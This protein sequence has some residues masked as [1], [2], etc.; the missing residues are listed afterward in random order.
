MNADGKIKELDNALVAKW[1]HANALL[2]MEGEVVERAYNN[3][4]WMTRRRG[5]RI[6][7][8]RSLSLRSAIYI[9]WSLCVHQY[10]SFWAL[11]TMQFLIPY[12]N[13]CLKQNAA[14]LITSIRLQTY[15]QQISM[16]I[17]YR[18]NIPQ[19]SSTIITSMPTRTSDMYMEVIELIKKLNYDVNENFR[20]S[21]GMSV[22]LIRQSLETHSAISVNPPAHIILLIHDTAHYIWR[23]KRPLHLH[24]SARLHEQVI[25]SLG[26]QTFSIGCMEWMK[27]KRTSDDAARLEWLQER[28]AAFKRDEAD[29]P[30]TNIS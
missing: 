17:M 23:Q 5:V 1:L 19:L 15:L 28:L 6:G 30:I 3:L 27:I 24:G 22:T 13:E 21:N 10:E 4:C 2:F 29:A 16:R 7:N 18:D 25:R 11:Q 20:L 26:Y 12:I 14:K 8:N 9:V